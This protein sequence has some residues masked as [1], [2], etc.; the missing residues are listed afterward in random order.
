M[1]YL[2]NILRD[3]FNFQVTVLSGIVIIILEIMRPIQH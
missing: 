1:L 3:V 2:E